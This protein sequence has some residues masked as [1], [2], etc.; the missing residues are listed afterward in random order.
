[1]DNLNDDWRGVGIIKN[2]PRVGLGGEMDTMAERRL[3]V[4]EKRDRKVKPRIRENED[5]Q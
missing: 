2:V 3:M 5:T 1:M 4:A